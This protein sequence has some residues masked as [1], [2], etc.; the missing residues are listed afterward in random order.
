MTA[1]RPGPIGLLRH[2]LLCLC[3][4]ANP[5]RAAELKVATWNL[6]WLTVRAPAAA[7]LP[8]DVV[9]RQPED[10]DRLAAYAAQL[11][12]DVVALQEVDGWDAAA[13]IFPRDRWAIHMTRDRLTQRVGIVIRRG[14]RF[15]PN[16]DV[17]AIAIDPSLRLRSGADVTLHLPGHD[18][19]LLAVHLKRGCQDQPL[20]RSTRRACI[21]LRAQLAPLQAWIADRE[22]DRA[23]YVVLG[24][25]NRWMDGRDRFLSELATA[26]PLHRATAGR[27]SPCWGNE[28]FIDH[29]LLGGRARD[30]LVPDSLRVL[31]YREQGEGW[32]DR[33][34]DHCPV[35]VRLDVPGE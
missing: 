34:S 21:E 13:R 18:L 24:D 3:L 9:P 25:F 12:A 4:L 16:P 19:R 7:G 2:A 29:I 11:D 17:T 30:W 33:L 31:T 32:R 20:A 28:A 26:A 27:S 6:N 8:R 23:A 1:V 35:S 10:L 22:R 5:A 15:E 14:I